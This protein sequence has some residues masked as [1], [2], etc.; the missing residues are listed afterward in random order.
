MLLSGMRNGL[1]VSIPA[2]GD[3]KFPCPNT[4]SLELVAGMTNSMRRPSG[5]D[6]NW[7]TP[8][9]RQIKCSLAL[10]LNRGR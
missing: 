7:R 6:V 9:Q 5:R 8:L 3:E 2:H 10:I 4:R 1:R